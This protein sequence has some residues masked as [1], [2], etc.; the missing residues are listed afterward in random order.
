[1]P[2]YKGRKGINS[3]PQGLE[4]LEK[5]QGRLKV[6]GWTGRRRLGYRATASVH[7]RCVPGWHLLLEWKLAEQNALLISDSLELCC[8]RENGR[9]HASTA[10]LGPYM[11]PDWIQQIPRRHRCRR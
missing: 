10:W 6:G 2:G 9:T 5:D 8:Q 11:M 3:G 4:T 7:G 1:V